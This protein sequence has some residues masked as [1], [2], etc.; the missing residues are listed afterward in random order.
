MTAR[1]RLEDVVASSEL[2]FPFE[3]AQLK[4][5]EPFGL[6]TIASLMSE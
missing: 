2:V 1:A 5:D 6:G 4:L 3:S